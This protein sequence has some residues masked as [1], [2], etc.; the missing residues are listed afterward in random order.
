MP[1]QMVQ[2]PQYAAQSAPAPTYAQPV[3]T[4]QAPLPPPDLAEKPKQAA[5]ADDKPETKQ[6]K[7]V[8]IFT[9]E[10]PAHEKVQQFTKQYCLPELIDSKE[11][12][13]MAAQKEQ[14][15]T[16]DTQAARELIPYVCFYNG[17]A[18]LEEMKEQPA[19]PLVPPADLLEGFKRKRD[20]IIGL[21]THASSSPDQCAK[22]LKNAFNPESPRPTAA[23]QVGF[24]LGQLPKPVEAASP[25][26]NLMPMAAKYEH[27]TYMNIYEYFCKKQAR[28]AK[29]DDVKQLPNSNQLHMP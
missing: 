3:V 2:P 17:L 7:F 15:S 6:Q 29:A 8:A 11:L 22:D 12:I 23:A 1:P 28:L 4:A 21:Q 13:S 25:L 5:N 26:D 27:N 14:P 16:E 9:S 19:K 24:S 20:F 18:V 10:M